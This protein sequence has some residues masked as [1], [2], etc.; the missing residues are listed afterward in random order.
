MKKHYVKRWIIN[1]LGYEEIDEDY[2]CM[3]THKIAWLEW[4][5][6][7]ATEEQMKTAIKRKQPGFHFSRNPPKTKPPKVKKVKKEVVDNE[8]DTER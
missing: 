8:T 1:L 3:Q 5:I 6:G 7:R 2:A 4:F